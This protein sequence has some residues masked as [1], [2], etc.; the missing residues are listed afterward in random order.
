M[1]FTDKQKERYNGKDDTYKKRERETKVYRNTD[2][3][4]VA[5]KNSL[6]KER[7]QHRMSKNVV[8]EMMVSCGYFFGNRNHHTVEMTHTLPN[9]WHT[10]N[11]IF[12]V[13]DSHI[14]Q[15]NA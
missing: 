10:E 4:D 15:K 1:G 14:E 6:N 3:C 12:K 11:N 8:S 5:T 9:F 7:K 13:L 2:R